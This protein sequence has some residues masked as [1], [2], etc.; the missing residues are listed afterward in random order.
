[1]SHTYELFSVYSS[2]RNQKYF[3]QSLFD[4]IQTYNFQNCRNNSL[5]ENGNCIGIN[6]I[7]V[8]KEEEVNQDNTQ[9]SPAAL[10]RREPEAQEEINETNNKCSLS[11]LKSRTSSAA[12]VVPD[13]N[14]HVINHKQD[15]IK[16]SKTCSA[17]L[18]IFNSKGKR[19]ATVTNDYVDNQLG[20]QRILRLSIDSYLFH[21]LRI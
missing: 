9:I 7:P 18:Y 15:S 19:C 16:H 14:N 2:L 1:M 11:S 20:M 12:T 6:I 4:Y 17:S 3:D 10:N 5:S 13:M 8:N 21:T